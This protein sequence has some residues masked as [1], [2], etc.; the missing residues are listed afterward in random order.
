MLRDM[1]NGQDK[2]LHSQKGIEKRH[3]INTGIHIHKKER[4]KEIAQSHDNFIKMVIP[5][6]LPTR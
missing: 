3:A 2:C 1:T 4:N 6:F 5:F